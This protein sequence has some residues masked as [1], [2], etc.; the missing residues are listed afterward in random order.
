MKKSKEQRKEEAEIRQEARRCRSTLIQLK[1]L[2][3]R[4]G[5]GVGAKLDLFITIRVKERAKLKERL[6]KERKNNA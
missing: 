2:N 6:E 5:F 4:L 1:I 3:L